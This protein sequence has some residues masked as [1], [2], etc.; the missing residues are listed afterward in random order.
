MNIKDIL[1]LL[2]HKELQQIQSDLDSGAVTIRKFVGDRIAHLDA[3]KKIC[4]T[5][6]E[7]LDDT[8]TYIYSV[9][10]GPSDFRKVATFCGRDCQDYFIDSLNKKMLSDRNELQG[11]NNN[12]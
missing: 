11:C 8:S 5:C 12:I 10:F 2:D 4:S 3:K 1:E 6:G 7:S 9:T